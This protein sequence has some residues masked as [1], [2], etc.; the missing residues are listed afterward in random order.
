MLVRWSTDVAARA[1]AAAN[2]HDQ[3][4]LRQLLSLSYTCHFRPDKRTNETEIFARSLKRRHG[5]LAA[6]NR[7]HLG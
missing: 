5:I 7:E 4:L 6:C 2:S 3:E 1:I